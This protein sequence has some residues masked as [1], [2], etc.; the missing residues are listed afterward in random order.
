MTHQLHHLTTTFIAKVSMIA[1]LSILICLPLSSLEAKEKVSNNSIIENL[2]IQLLEDS[3]F[4][5]KLSEKITPSINDDYIREIVKDYLLKNPEIMIEMQLVLQ[6]KLGGIEEQQAFIIKSLE[7]E[8]FH[9]FHDAVFGNPNGKITLVE[10]F[11]YNCN[12]CKRSY[13]SMVNLIKEYPDLRIIIKDLPILG[14]DSIEAH[15]IAYAFRQQ[16]PEKYFQFYKELLSGQNRANKAKAIKIAVSL[17]ANEKD[18]HNAI[19]NPNLQKSF[20]RNIQIASVLNINGTPS[21]II[22]DRIFM[23]AVSEDILKK[24]IESIQ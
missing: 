24:V 19:Q 15:T 4:L 3:T 8:I 7:K 9:S 18:L 14:P 20:K 22:G 23:G 1:A 12:F 16:L 5:S 6:E 13:P 11:D 10:F 21:Y 2:K 17:G